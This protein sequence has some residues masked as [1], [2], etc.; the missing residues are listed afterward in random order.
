MSYERL[1]AHH[2]ELAL[3]SSVAALLE[4]DERTLMPPAAGPYRAEQLT[5][6]AG[7]IHRRRTDPA[8]GEWLDAAGDVGGDPASPEATNVRELRRA[9]DKESRRPAELVE[10]I[11]RA[12]VIGQQR[13]QA[14]RAANDFASFAPSLE[15]IV[16]LRREESAALGP[17]EHPY[18]PLLDDYEPGETAATVGP[19]LREL[20]D[21]LVP[22]VRAIADDGRPPRRDVLERRYAPDAQAAFARDAAAAIGFDFDAGR[23]DTSAHPF[24]SGVAPR[25]C[26][27]TTRY[28]ERFFSGAFFGVLHE[29]GHG[30]YEQGLD[31]DAF[32]L[33][34]GSAVSLGIHESQSRLWENLVGRRRSFWEHFY[35]T[36][37]AA[38][39]G[40]LDDVT[41]DEFHAAIND[42]RPSLIRV[43]ADELTYN[44]HILLRFE[45]ECALMTGDLSVGDLPGAWNDAMARDLGITPPDDTNGVLQDIHWGAGLVGYFPTYALGNVFASQL[46]ERAAVELGDLDAQ[47]A[48]GEFTPLRDWLR[49]HVHRP[50]QARPARALIEHV[51]GTPPA[52]DA[53]LRHVR[54]VAALHGI[55]SR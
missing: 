16:A 4:W 14:A 6:L 37:R 52:P 33:P 23:L 34:A 20:R 22:I 28:L 7:M 54:D 48:A 47:F 44:L 10:R 11:T 40:T 13:W 45:L 35:P 17:T 36:L 19:V 55:E 26:R 27:I 41:L 29:A 39:P 21:E 9:F 31:P 43:E 18:D 32:G 2:R 15:T 24:C 46:F 38:F 3:L 12:T 51:T 53:L 8:I 42:V 50:G 25:D 49:V 5:A 30:I 1:I